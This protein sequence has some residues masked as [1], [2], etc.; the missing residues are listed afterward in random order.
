MH[1]VGFILRI[2]HDAR[3]LEHTHKKNSSFCLYYIQKWETARK[4]NKAAPPSFNNKIKDK[5][6]QYWKLPEEMKISRH[7]GHT[8]NMFNIKHI[9]HGIL[10]LDTFICGLISSMHM[11]SVYRAGYKRLILTAHFLNEASNPHKATSLEI[12]EIR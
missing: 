9:R 1:L 7:V 10:N 12:N 4:A 3:S 5:E 2:Y 6:G 11:Q 8:L